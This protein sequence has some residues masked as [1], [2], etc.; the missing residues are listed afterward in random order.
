[1]EMKEIATQKNYL[2]SAKVIVDFESLKTDSSCITRLGD[3]ITLTNGIANEII[4]GLRGSTQ[5]FLYSV[6]LNFTI[7]IT[8]YDSVKYLQLS[9][10]YHDFLKSRHQFGSGETLNF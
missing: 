4:K 8:I 6:F 5:P 7:S 3:D 10:F 2:E 1:M 9:Y